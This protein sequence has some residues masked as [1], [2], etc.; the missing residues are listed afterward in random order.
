MNGQWILGALLGAVWFVGGLRAVRWTIR[1]A[2]RSREASAEGTW[3]YG[4]QREMVKD[5]PRFEANVHYFVSVGAIGLCVAI[6]AVFALVPIWLGILGL[7]MALLAAAD[8]EARVRYGS[9]SVADVGR[10]FRSW[11]RLSP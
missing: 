8:V 4:V 9:G 6:A 10:V 3:Q 2:L 5:A 1:R 11:L 7:A